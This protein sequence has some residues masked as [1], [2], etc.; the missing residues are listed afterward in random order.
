MSR[1]RFIHRTA[2]LAGL[3]VSTAL[4]VAGPPVNE[5]GLL[6]DDSGVAPAAGSQQEHSVARGGDVSLVVWSDYRARDAGS[7]SIQSDGDILGIRIDAAGNPLDAAPFMIAGGMGLQQR[8]QVAWNGSAWLVVYISQD[9]VGEYFDNVLRAVRVSAAGQVLDA[10][11]ISFPPAQYSPSTLGLAVAGQQGQWLVTRCL[12]HADGYGTSLS[13]QRVGADG[14]LLDPTPLVLNDWVYGQTRTL[15]AGGEYLLVGPD[16]YD[17]AVTKARRIGLSGAPIAP[18]FTVPSQTITSNGSEYYVAWI[19][20][21]VNLVGSRMTLSGTLLTPTGTTLVTNFSQYHSSTLTHD[22][23]SWWLAWGASDQIRTVRVASTGAVLDPGGGVLMPITIGGS[24]NNAYSPQLV[25]RTGGGVQLY[26]YDVRAALGS[27]SNVFALPVSPANVAETERCVST[28]TTNQRNS[29]LAA[30]PNGSAAVVFVSERAGDDRVLLQFVNAADV[31]I[32]TGPIEVRRAPTI[33]RTGVAWNGSIYMV[34][35]DEGPS[36][37]TSTSV[38]ARRLNPDGTFIDAAPISV[39]PGAAADVEALG[40][41]FLVACTRV[42]AYPQNIFLMGNRIDGP[43]GA[44]LDGAS[45]MSLGGS[46]VSGVPRVRSDG[47]KWYV[48][49]HSMWS[50][51]SSQGDAIYATVPPVGPPV[52]AVNPT[53]YSGGSG[54][55]DI[56]FSGSVSLLVWRNNS[57]SNA[58]NSIAGRIMLSN[59]ALQPAFVIAEAPGRQLRPTVAWDGQNFVV[60][61]ED[62]RN[63]GAFFDARTDVYATRVSEAGVVLDPSAFAVCATPEGDTAPSILTR[64]PGRTL[65]TS[66]RFVTA[67]P[68]DSYRVGLTRVGSIAMM[69][70]AN[71]DLRVDFTDVLSVLANWQ[72]AGPAGDADHNGLVNFTDITAV[73]GQWGASM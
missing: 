50:H 55:L 66:S 7:Q 37:L 36:G 23:T 41:D 25:G 33:G 43:T 49:A 45:G 22:G 63:Q 53:P 31:P 32:G 54:D 34:A 64:G 58:N 60:A 68:F 12:Y 69:G 10:T 13:G 52:Q 1:S 20:D 8:P 18:S 61:W 38:K 30:G 59:G 5:L 27:D 3:C 57:L 67:A 62:E 17:S 56:A 65:I 35:W 15:V 11:P 46:Y 29:D 14:T 42:G 9:P 28:G 39:M 2:A 70:D 6:P 44:V 73:L 26:W 48:A 47:T 71:E 16:W 4:V 40:E 72:S 24:I 51:N 19:R 21:Y